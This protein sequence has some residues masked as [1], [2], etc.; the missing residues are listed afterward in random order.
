MLRC[1]KTTS[2]L[3]RGTCCVR[4]M[5]LCVSRVAFV[6]PAQIDYDDENIDANDIIRIFD[7][8][9]ASGVACSRVVAYLTLERRDLYFNVFKEEHTCITGIS[10]VSSL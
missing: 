4:R 2:R 3:A 9:V 8:R 7:F 6:P 1:T 5:A 10:P